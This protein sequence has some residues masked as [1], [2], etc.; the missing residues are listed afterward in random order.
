VT[1]TDAR[2]ASI[3]VQA[4]S[5]LAQPPG[6]VLIDGTERRGKGGPLPVIDPGTGTTITEITAAAPVEVD[7]AVAAARVAFD[8][9]RWSRLDPSRREE[10]LR[11]IA[12]R[13]ED[14]AELV[15]ELES[16]DTGKP[17]AQ[18]AEDVAEAVA[19]LRY[20]A[21]WADK[22]AGS[23]IAAPQGLA[24]STLREPLGVCAAITP[25]NYP[26]PILMYKLAPALVCG[27]TFVAKP[28]EYASLST[29]HFARLCQ[30]AGLPDGVVNVITG[31]ADAGAAL[32]AHADLD[33]IAFT[34]STATGRAVAS[35]AART[36][37]AV[38]LEL[39]GKSPQVVFGD[40]DLD[41]A[42]EG[43]LAGIWTNAG[44]VCVAGSR[45]LVDTR[46]HDD[47]VAELIS[48]T[49]RERLGHGLDPETTMGPVITETQRDR[50]EGFIDRAVQVGASAT[51][52]PEVPSGDGFFVSPTIVTAVA[53]ESKLFHEEVFGPV[54]AVTPFD[55]ER[56]AVELANGTGY[57]LAAGLWTRD[58]SRAQRLAQAVRAGSVW[59]NT[60]GIFHPTLPFGGVRGSG[61]GRELGAEAVYRYTESKT[62]VINHT[63]R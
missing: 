63:S 57:G 43:V 31:A 21:G 23:T 32:A 10:T 55:G 22:I 50:V 53:P 58:V 39:G 44:Q 11:R 25:W 9:G 59:V 41:A 8:D 49:R 4:R 12:T 52:G 61:Y 13:L 5:W 20:Y 35:A 2:R 15:V 17:R 33:K 62:L 14:E 24:A 18:A 34:G 30:E 40:A 6:G 1:P 51:R 45:L 27:N 47:F 56:Q 60:F 48:R 38:T 54:L 37:T 7:D 42:A 29:L 26:L 3:G 19:V 16:L 36:T 46:V 28:S